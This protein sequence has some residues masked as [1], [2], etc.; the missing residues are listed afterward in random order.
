MSRFTNETYNFDLRD[1]GAGFEADGAVNVDDKPVRFTLEVHKTNRWVTIDG[2]KVAPEAP[3]ENPLF[4]WMEPDSSTGWTPF[5]TPIY[6]Q[7]TKFLTVECESDELYGRV[8]N[9]ALV[10]AWCGRRDE[11]PEDACPYCHV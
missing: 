6:D 7:M 11:E 3:E 10:Q 4:D 1:C 2:I 9:G 5:E 8:E